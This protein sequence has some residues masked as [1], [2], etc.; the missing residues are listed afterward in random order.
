MSKDTKTETLKKWKNNIQ[1]WNQIL[2]N[3][4]RYI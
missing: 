2:L 1:I 4:M 3:I